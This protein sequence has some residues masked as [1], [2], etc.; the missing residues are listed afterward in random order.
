MN[1]FG[2]TLQSKYFRDHF[3]SAEGKDIKDVQVKD[4]LKPI[5]KKMVDH[6]YQT[7]AIPFQKPSEFVDIIKKKMI[8]FKNVVL[9]RLLVIANWKVDKDSM[10]IFDR[11]HKKQTADFLFNI[12]DIKKISPCSKYLGCVD[13]ANAKFKLE[14]LKKGIITK[15]H[16]IRLK[17]IIDL[18]KSSLY[19]S[20]ETPEVWITLIETTIDYLR[21]N[22]D[23]HYIEWTI[24][25]WIK[26]LHPSRDKSL[27]NTTAFVHSFLL[28]KILLKKKEDDLST[29]T[30]NEQDCIEWAKMNLEKL[31]LYCKDVN[32]YHYFRSSISQLSKHILLKKKGGD[33]WKYFTFCSKKINL[34]IPFKDLKQRCSTVPNHLRLT[35][36]DEIILFVSELTKKYTNTKITLKYVPCWS[37]SGREKKRQTYYSKADSKEIE[38]VYKEWKNNP[39]PKKVHKLSHS[40]NSTSVLAPLGHEIVFEKDKYHQLNCSTGAERKITRC[41]LLNAHG[42]MR[43]AIFA[44]SLALL[45]TIPY[46]HECR[47]KQSFNELLNDLVIITGSTTLSQ[48]N[49]RSSKPKK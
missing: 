36:G 34:E 17:T 7:K 26:S 35:S 38:E 42:V 19:K 20:Y 31:F 49:P 15:E 40:M 4:D 18:C 30:L 13:Y 5:Y 21:F 22:F 2:T 16:H 39:S 37:W 46:D 6:Y 12:L 25:S 41:E 3:Y 10:A 28:N 32:S 1:V 43:Y 44:K 9:A 14:L 23:V 33:I 48:S 29:L 11:L 8:V 27:M 45:H 24:S 47:K